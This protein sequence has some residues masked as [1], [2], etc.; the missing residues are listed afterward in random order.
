M[1]P[2][3]WK[4]FSFKNSCRIMSFLICVSHSLFVRLMNSKQYKC[5]QCCYS[6]HIHHIHYYHLQHLQK[7]SL[8]LLNDIHHH[9]HIHHKV[10]VDLVGI[11]WRLLL[12]V[13]IH[14]P[15]SSPTFNPKL[16]PPARRYKTTIFSF[17]RYYYSIHFI[18]ILL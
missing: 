11:L 5:F 13:I 16:Y 18:F 10:F 7:V 8:Q 17:Y 15:P 3:D 12:Y 2:I 4:N 6:H 9:N 1:D 14:I